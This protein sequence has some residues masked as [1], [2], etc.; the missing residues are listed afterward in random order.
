MFEISSLTKI[1]KSALDVVG[2]FTGSA[3]QA[4]TDSTIQDAA[5]VIGAG[6]P[7]IQQFMNGT[8][9]TLDQMRA[10]LAAKDTALA[11]FDAELAR[12]QSQQT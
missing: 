6:L 11:D 1:L 4:R 7:L 5:A 3:A 12:Q 2:A 9:V 8:P 10:S